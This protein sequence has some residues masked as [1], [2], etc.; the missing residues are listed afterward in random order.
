MIW[1]QEKVI[2][3]DFNLYPRFAKAQ[4]IR[5]GSSLA[6]SY[7]HPAIPQRSKTVLKNPMQVFRFQVFD[8]K[9]RVV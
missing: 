1:Y 5:E 7:I 2:T 9:I 3:E 4:S 6:A 8:S